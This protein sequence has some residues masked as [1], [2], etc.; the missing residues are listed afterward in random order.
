[1][2]KKFIVCEGLKV[3]LNSVSSLGSS[4]FPP[5]RRVE[6]SV[7]PCTVQQAKMQFVSGCQ[8]LLFFV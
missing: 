7:C 6:L 1:M 2:N 3:Q 5:L 8:R 4:L